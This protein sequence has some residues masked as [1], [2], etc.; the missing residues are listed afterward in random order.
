MLVCRV[1]INSDLAVSWKGTTLI[2]F[3]PEENLFKHF[4][5]VFPLVLRAGMSWYGHISHQLNL[6]RPSV[7]LPPSS[8]LI[9]AT[10]A[11]FSE[12]DCCLLFWHPPNPCDVASLLMPPPD[13]TERMCI[14]IHGFGSMRWVLVPYSSL[15]AP[16]HLIC[17]Y[18]E[19]RKP[20]SCKK[21]VCPSSC[22]QQD[23]VL[24]CK[25]IWRLWQV[26]K[27]CKLWPP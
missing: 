6:L 1:S 19:P 11:T 7:S 26:R 24:C 18:D 15:F 12:F 5:C 20:S 16:A 27:W 17:L 14:P 21:S 22:N 13:G 8:L 3:P 25:D 2:C 9:P 4:I 23:L 10:Y